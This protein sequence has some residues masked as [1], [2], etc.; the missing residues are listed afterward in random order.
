MPISVSQDSCGLVFLYLSAFT[1]L[2]SLNVTGLIKALMDWIQI[3]GVFCYY[4]Q[5][6]YYHMKYIK[7]QKA[8]I[9]IQKV[10]FLLFLFD[11]ELSLVYR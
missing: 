4:F 10:G 9:M 5:G 2:K 6:H 1:F 3:V 7:I 8:V 11:Q